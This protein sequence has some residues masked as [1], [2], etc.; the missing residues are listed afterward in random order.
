MKIQR[1]KQVGGS[2]KL[3]RYFKVGGVIF[4]LLIIGEILAVSRLSTYGNEIKQLN[5]KKSDL[6]LENLLLK[7]QLSTQE[8]LKNLEKE[9]KMYGFENIK[10]IE[11]IK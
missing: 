8:S 11:Y 7:D 5:D 9:S 2:S 10:D 1:L 3:L 4:V 6:E